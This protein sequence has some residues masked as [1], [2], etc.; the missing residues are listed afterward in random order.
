MLK[1]LQLSKPASQASL[2]VRNCPSQRARWLLAE[3]WTDLSPGSAALPQS[4]RR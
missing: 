4:P 1:S 3:L 2:P